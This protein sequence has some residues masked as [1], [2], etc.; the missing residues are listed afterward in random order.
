MDKNLLLKK[1]KNK[2]NQ[3]LILIVIIGL[4]FISFFGEGQKVREEVQNEN[5]VKTEEERLTQILEDIDMA[6]E[7]SVMITYYGT[8]EKNIAYETRKN[9]SSLGESESYDEKA[10]MTDGSPMVINE[11]YPRVKGVIVTAEGADNA[12]VRENLINAVSSE[13]DVEKHRVCI[14]KK[15]LP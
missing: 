15:S 5:T 10:V 12:A 13:L 3:R 7:V 6:G 2:N 9:I 8:N 14:Y 1:L 4:I 11:V